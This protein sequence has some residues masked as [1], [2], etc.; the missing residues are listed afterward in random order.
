[1][2]LVPVGNGPR[3][4][5]LTPAPVQPQAETD[6]AAPGVMDTIGAAWRSQNIIGSTMANQMIGAD[7]DTIEPDFNPFDAAKGTPYEAY[8][9]RLASI[10]NRKAFESFKAQVDMEEEDRR[11]L[12]AAGGWGVLAQIGAG[13]AD[14]TILIPAGSLVRSGR[15]GFSMLGSAAAVGAGTAAGIAVQE[16]ALQA[17]QETRTAGESAMAIGGGAILGAIVGAAGARLFDNLAWREIGKRLSDEINVKGPLPIDVN[18]AEMRAFIEANTSAEAASAGAAAV[19][20][21]TAEALSPAGRAAQIA[22]KPFAKLNPLLRALTSPS[23]AYKRVALSLMENPVYLKANVEGRASE[24]AVESLVKGATGSY[25]MALERTFEEFKAA[26]KA[27][28][29]GG[30][31]EFREAVGRA[32]RMGDVDPGGNEFITRAAQDWR[33]RVWEPLKKQ[34]IDAGILPEGVEA[35]T[36]PSYF[37]RMYSVRMIEAN[38][39]EFKQIVR[40]W[41]RDALA[42]QTEAEAGKLGRKVGNLQSEINDLDMQVLRRNAEAQARATGGE[43]DVDA[44]TERSILRTLEHLR[45][46]TKKP[47][48][49]S[50]TQFLQRKGGL[51]DQNGELEALGISNKTRPGFVRKVRQTTSN[52]NGG[53]D[54]DTAARMA[55]EDGFLPGMDRPTPND[56]LDALA[57]DFNGRRRIV[58]EEDRAAAADAELMDRIASDLERM[59][60]DTGTGKPMFS[61]SEDLKGFVRRISQALDNADRSRMD[62]LRRIKRDL[63]SRIVE[64]RP[65]PDDRLAGMQ[66]DADVEEVVESIF[67]KITGRGDVPQGENPFRIVANSRGPL[68]DR[69]FNIEDAKIEKFLE[70]DV[71]MVGRRYSRVMSADSEIAR[72]Y[73]KP[74]LEEQIREIREEYARLREGAETERQRLLLADRERSDIKDLMAVRDM[75]RGQ[76]LPEQNG[77][78]YARILNAAMTF[79]YIRAM[80]GVVAASLTDIARPIMVHGLRSFMSDGVAPLVRNLKAFRMSA[81]EAKLAG[82]VGERIRDG[83]LSTLAE[84][85]DPYA[86]GSPFERWLENGARAFGKATG[87]PLWNDFMKSFSGVMTQNRIIGNAAG[88]ASLGE[89]ELRYMRFLGIDQPMA[90]RIAKQFADHGQTLDGVRVANTEDWTDDVAVRTYRA[91][92]AKDV[93]SIIVTKGVGDI[94]LFGRTPTGRALLQFKGFA[95]AAHQRVLIRGLQEDKRRL[96]E[97]LIASATIGSFIYYL[98]SVESNRWEDVSDN[99]GRWIAEGLDRSGVFPLMFEANNVAE[100]VGVP[101]L[102]TGLQALFPDAMQRAPASRYAVRS[103]VDG[104]LGPTIGMAKDLADVVAL[105]FRRDKEGNWAGVSA[106][107]FNTMRRLTP[108]ATLPVIRSLIEY[109]ALPA[110]KEKFANQ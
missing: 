74:N 106:S 90:E 54:L 43:V 27:G 91:A 39:Q 49:E 66:R 97:G 46:G 104:L 89:K 50:L 17:T 28:Y 108:G 1:M 5:G 75:L 88:W 20:R 22:V 76:Y 105:P 84:L 36:S 94:P 25:T 41:A 70:S 85:T 78:N 93:D 80:G 3:D 59:G 16:G 38:E 24:V 4:I 110:L 63:E 83:A 77:S 65:A 21:E 2:P 45:A 69:T 29:K 109:E 72:K 44:A 100:K 37:H 32:G 8:P 14:P 34:A 12:H 62:E 56:L 30:Y 19:A 102:Y 101:G 15:I 23:A 73:G 53:L 55:W 40:D 52:K 13:V 92:V 6:L 95:M 82:T 96:L 10:F 79:N 71:A 61:T 42:R 103:I 98:K 7:F 47:Q 64:L 58:R 51:F 31:D 57:D 9:E 87:M 99:P 35:T 26:R 81:R 107:D 48:P 11:T 33:A 18:D 68:K 67:N 86:K 60:I